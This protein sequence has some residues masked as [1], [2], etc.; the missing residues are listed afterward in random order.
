MLVRLF[1]NLCSLFDLP[2]D[3]IDIKNVFFNGVL[4]EEIYIEQSPYYEKQPYN[5]NEVC[6]LKKRLYRLRQAPRVWFLEIDSKFWKMGSRTFMNVEGLYV[7]IRFDDQ[8]ESDHCLY[9][10]LCQ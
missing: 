1:F 7:S 5:Y 10:S 8:G 3:H 4:E 9:S 6:R 2:V